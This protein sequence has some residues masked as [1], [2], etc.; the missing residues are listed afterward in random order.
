[1]RSRR[2]A[3]TGGGHE[4]AF[5]QAALEQL[6]EPGRIGHVGLSARDVLD[7]VGVDQQQLEAFE[8]LE[9]CHTGRQ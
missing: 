2:R 5:Q 1:V 8:I 7:V 3:I 4:A 9:Q 6:G